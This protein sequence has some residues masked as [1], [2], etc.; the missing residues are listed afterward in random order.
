[1]ESI[2]T[3]PQDENN[4]AKGTENEIV[5]LSESEE[6]GN[7]ANMLTEDEIIVLSSSDQ[8]DW[9]LVCQ[10][11]SVHNMNKNKIRNVFIWNQ[12]LQEKSHIFK[13]SCQK[14]IVW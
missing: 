6:E 8:E 13:T 2:Q 3:V 1:M 5:L 4:G 11:A 14:K 12:C 9:L 7:G 10:Y